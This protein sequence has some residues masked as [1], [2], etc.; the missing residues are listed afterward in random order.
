VLGA[1]VLHDPRGARVDAS[2]TQ[3]RL[4]SRVSEDPVY[5]R[6]NVSLHLDK[7]AL[8]VGAAAHLSEL[9]DGGHPVLGV[10][11][12]GGDPE[13]RTADELVVFLIYNA[14]RDVA[15]DE[16]ECEVESFRAQTV[17]LVDLD[18]KVDEIRSHVPLQLGL[19]I[20]ELDRSHGHFLRAKNPRQRFVSFNDLLLKK[21]L[22]KKRTCISNMYS[23]TSSR[24]SH[25]TRESHDLSPWGFC[26]EEEQ[27]EARHMG[28]ER[29]LFPSERGERM[30]EVRLR[31]TGRAA[32][33]PV[34]VDTDEKL[35]DDDLITKKRERKEAV[36]CAGV[37]GEKEKV[38][39]VR[40]E[41]EERERQR[42]R[43]KSE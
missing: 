41:C 2:K 6:Q 1:L 8:V 39:A 20:D 25:S 15:I 5:G 26:E 24:Y 7:G 23:L 32:V 28:A 34:R 36:R 31:E 13:G 33:L 18:E 43:E 16:V 11:E 22:R 17:L 27:E 21:R 12:L 10:L 3:P 19:H 29:R 4:C 9:G 30:G 14:A 38:G 37:R 35:D 40:A 42:G